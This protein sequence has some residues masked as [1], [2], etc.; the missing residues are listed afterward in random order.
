M[1]LAQ[2]RA[3]VAVADAGGFTKAAATLGLT[4]SGVSHVVAALERELQLPLVTRTRGGVRLTVHGQLI[5]G[6]A[7]EAV[8]RVERISE[9][10]ATATRRRRRRI[11]VAT[12]PSAGQLLPSLIAAYAVRLPEVAVVL[13]EGSDAEVRTWLDDRLVDAG[14][15]ADLDGGSAAEAYGVVLHRDRML[16]VV[17]PG[18]P[19]AGQPSVQLAELADDPFLLSDNG[20]EPLLRRLYEDAGEPLQPQR[21]I[22]DMATLLALVREQLGVTVVPELSL[23]GAQG[24]VAIPLDPPAHRVLRL[25]PADP[26]DADLAVRTLL[27]VATAA[28]G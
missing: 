26:D 7:R 24:L 12:F 10:A 19:L 27:T 11:R 3:L 15:V 20:C 25:V 2:L 17:E 4:Q 6:H 5:I 22:R 16:A 9:V 8:A 18:H 21:R 13:L 1:N 23:T 28:A 14:V